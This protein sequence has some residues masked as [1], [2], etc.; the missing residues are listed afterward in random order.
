VA[1]NRQIA[2]SGTRH[3]YTM[4]PQWDTAPNSCA[5]CGVCGC[6]TEDHVIPV[7]GMSQLLY[8][9]NLLSWI[10]PACHECNL[11]LNNKTPYVIGG[12][13]YPRKQFERK[14]KMARAYIQKKYLGKKRVLWT[15][16]ELSNRHV[17]YGSLEDNE[18]VSRGLAEWI[19]GS[20]THEDIM[21]RLKYNCFAYD[22][23][24]RI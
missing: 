1:C 9:K 6:M 14:R 2:V 19:H 3:R 7:S 10:V 23:S 13:N 17:P 18:H 4:G 11:G 20:Y 22:Y 16:K 15:D 24:Y 12:Q 21:A 5:Y 8:I